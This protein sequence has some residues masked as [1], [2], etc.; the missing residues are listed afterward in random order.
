MKRILINITVIALI[1]FAFSCED[2]EPTPEFKKSDAQLSVSP[3]TSTVAVTATDSLTDVISFTWTDPDY[4]VGLPKSKFS[5]RVG[6]SDV[7]FTTFLSKDFTGVLSGSLLGKELNGM[8]LRLGGV[9]GEPITLDVMVVSSQSN[10]NEPKHSN[11]VK[12]TVTPYGDLSLTPSV[13]S[14][15][16]NATQAGDEAV[17]LTWSTAFV[18]F[19]GVKTYELQHAKGGTDFASPTTVEATNFKKSFT[20]FELN[21]IALGYGIA[22]GSSGP[23]DFR[24]KAT[25]ELGTVVYSNVATVNV[26][27]Y[28]AFV[29]IGI[30]GDATPGGWTTDTD[31]YRPDATKPTEWTATVYLVGGKEAKFRADDDWV[32]N[33][34]SSAFPSGTGT[35]NGPNIPVST[36]GY[37][38]VNLNVGTGAY[39]FTPVTTTVYTFISLIGAQT[40]WGSDI[41]DLTKD[42]AN[43]QVWSGVVH[44]KA[45]ELKFR[46]NHAWDVNWGPVPGT[47][48]TSLSG[49]SRPGDGNMEIATEGDYFVYFNAATGEYFFGKADR[50]DAFAD[51]GVIGDATPGGWDND[52]NLI[53]NPSNPYKWSGT[54]TLTDGEAKFRAD[55]DWAVNWGGNTFPGGVATQGGPNIP[56]DPGVYFVTFNSSTGEYF[57][58]K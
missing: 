30:I 48:P 37:Y 45:G 16:T 29:S 58:L 42:P 50:D 4:A 39:T 25:N 21:K 24:V 32:D 28:I 52:T 11:I 34:G 31:L 55:N 20:H 47:T 5:L 1:G 7:N 54:I 49:Y 13:S 57:F 15:T 36:T 41:A 33:W 9:I 17:S 26:T 14:L 56:A 8:A 44:L 6:A 23:I 27:P 12:I 10:N 51:V 19:K 18:G 46:A 53:K 3:S 2:V 38:K 22:A 35:Q 40:G 43:D